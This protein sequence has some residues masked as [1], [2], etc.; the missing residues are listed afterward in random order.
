[1]AS[2]DPTTLFLL[3]TLPRRTPARAELPTVVPTSIFLPKEHG[4]WSLAFE[5]LALGMLLAP[6]LAGGAF[7]AAAVAVF[8]ARRPG[9]IA[10]SSEPVKGWRESRE[11]LVV[12]S[13]LVA[14]GGFE[15]LVLADG[16]GLWPLLIAAP[17]C[18]LFAWFDSKGQGRAAAAELCGTAAFGFLPAV[19]S[20]L[21]GLPPQVALT[22]AL[23]AL[24]RSIPT[25][26]TV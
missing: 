6:S 22:F 8:F 4:S 17:F 26:L 13:S 24:I 18:L 11:A 1:M 3:P 20:A 2:T 16:R 19:F 5:P 7:L 21:A 25:V 14:A 23:L 15:A 9:K 12:L 10:F